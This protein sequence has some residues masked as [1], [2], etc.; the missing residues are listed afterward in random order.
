MLW[1]YTDAYQK[2]S[3]KYTGL[4]TTVL[5]AQKWNLD[6]GIFDSCFYY[7]EAQFYMIIKIPKNFT[8]H[9]A[10]RKLYFL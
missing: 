7:R 1:Q 4:K 6:F 10:Y 5:F 9:L 2:E 3:F 8:M